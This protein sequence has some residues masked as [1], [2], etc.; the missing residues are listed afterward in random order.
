MLSVIDEYIYCDANA[1][2]ASAYLEAWWILGIDEC[3]TR[4]QEVLEFLWTSLR[5]T[6]GGMCHYWDGAAR[7]PGL[8][9]DA[10]VTGSAFL[11]A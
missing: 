11:D 1:R 2:A 3:R 8:L 7:V 9:T 4:A 5:G 6:G 10:T